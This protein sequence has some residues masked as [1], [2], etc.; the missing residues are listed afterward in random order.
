M[1]ATHQMKQFV[2]CSLMIYTLNVN[3]QE[4]DSILAPHDALKYRN[5]GPARG[6]RVTT[7][8]GSTN[9]PGVFYMGATGGGVWKTSDY[10]QKWTN[11]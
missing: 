4:K 9:E 3:A 7:V 1:K 5:I 8:A 6:G 10:G 11:I 2:L